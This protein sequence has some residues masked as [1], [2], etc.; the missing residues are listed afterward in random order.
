MG[1]LVRLW[2]TSL[3]FRRVV[4]LV[5]FA[6]LA[7]LVYLGS[8]IPR[9]VSLPADDLNK[10]AAAGIIDEQIVIEKPV[11]AEGDLVLSYVGNRNEVADIWLD[12]ATLDPQ[13]RALFGGSAT[14]E[15]I[16]YTTGADPAGFKT[17][18]TC[19]TTIEVRR[20]KGSP[21][22]DA[23]RLYQTDETQGAQRFRQIVVDPG[24]A[25]LDVVLHT[26]SP[27]EGSSDYAGCHKQ[28]TLGG[29]QPIDL[30]L[31]PLH[32]VAQRGKLDLHFNPSNPA[33]PIFTAGGD[34]F[35][36]VSLGSGA[37]QAAQ[38][39]V[40]AVAHPTP[41]KLD[42]RPIR[43]TQTITVRDLKI[44]SDRLSVDLGRDGE[45]ALAS[46]NGHSIYNYDLIDT[47]Q[48]NPILSF[49]F[50]AVM[51]PALWAWARKNCFP[52][53]ANKPPPP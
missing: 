37:L 36:G 52:G 23:L 20:A 25:T 39:S 42:V 44:A 31:I 40:E 16:S 48:K 4:T 53:P 7:G 12:S 21:P 38:F 51:V 15:Q 2:K 28:L 13:S 29:Q 19:H 27:V 50:A 11:L 17:D 35:Q 22:I 8:H 47:I 46:A 45:A 30:P 9:S 5:V 10:L 3:L 32:I 34:S 49:V 6:S 43:A 41:G 33:V 14:P 26:D 18:D 1:N 24:A